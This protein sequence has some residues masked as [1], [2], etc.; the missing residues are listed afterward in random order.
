VM[1]RGGG[2][3]EKEAGRPSEGAPHAIAARAVRKEELDPLSPRTSALSHLE[4]S[5]FQDVNRKNN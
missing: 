5:K 3:E 4:I 1:S 2:V